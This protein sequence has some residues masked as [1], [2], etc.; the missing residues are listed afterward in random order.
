[1]STADYE[2]YIDPHILFSIKIDLYRGA[3]NFIF[4]NTFGEVNVKLNFFTE[5]KNF[6]NV[7]I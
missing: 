4:I 2:Q 1:M 7:L 6:F 3:I 5:K